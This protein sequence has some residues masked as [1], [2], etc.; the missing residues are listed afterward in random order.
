MT[1]FK[2]D[3]AIISENMCEKGSE[4]KFCD[5]SS[6]ILFN[7]WMDPHLTWL[8]RCLKGIPIYKQPA[9]GPLLPGQIRQLQPLLIHETYRTIGSVED[10]KPCIASMHKYKFVDEG[11]SIFKWVSGYIL[12]LHPNLV[13]LNFFLLA[14]GMV[15]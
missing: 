5:H 13:K 12:H 15:C 7:F 4:L 11:S 3:T 6:S 14:A 1:D 10:V 8:D 9:Q 2:V